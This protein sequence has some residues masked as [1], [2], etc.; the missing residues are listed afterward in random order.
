M[1]ETIF[2]SEGLEN[3]KEYKKVYESLGKCGVSFE[4]LPCRENVWCRDFMPVHIGGGKNV[5]Y[6]YNPDYLQ[7]KPK[8]I[9]EQSAACEGL[10]INFA[11]TMDITFDGGNYVRCGDKV[12]VTDKIFMENPDWRPLRLLERLEEAFQAQVILLPWDMVEEYGHADGMVAWLGG[13]RILLNNYSQLEKDEKKPFTTRLQKILSA[14]FDVTEL[15]YDCKVHEDSWCY[16]NFLETERA[17]IMP[18]LSEKKNL[19][20][21]IAALELF[22]K[23]FPDKKVVQVYAEPLVKDGGA[24][25]CVTWE[26]YR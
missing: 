6:N 23:I 3:A 19:D 7:D 12:L 18:T 22:Q 15:H 20:N 2:I 26:L 5:G 11:D 21:D 13:D 4:K 25:H 14:H 10:D 24:L 9:I 8:E 16:L 1:T 17:I